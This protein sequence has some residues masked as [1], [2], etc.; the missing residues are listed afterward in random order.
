MRILIHRLG[1]LGDTIVALPVFKLIRETYP[2]AHITVLTNPPVSE[3]AAPLEAVIE[4]MGLV[5]EAL[6]YPMASR[7]YAKLAK[8]HSEIRRHRFDLYVSI[9]F[10][11]HITSSIRDYLYFKTCG[12]G[13]IIGLPFAHCDR[14][15]VPVGDGPLYEA[16]AT[17]LLRRA[18]AINPALADR[19]NPN[20]PQWTDLR[21]TPNELAQ[22]DDLLR[23][24]GITGNFLVASVG[25]KLRQKDWG[26]DRWNEL[27]SR[28]GPR[29][30]DF[31]MVMLGSADESSRSQALLDLW[32][33]P[34]ANL[35]GKCGPRV[36]AAVMRHA[37]LF[38]GHDSGP[39]H[40]AAAAG[41]RCV[42]I[43]CAHQPPGRWFPLGHGHAVFYP[44]KFYRSESWDDTEYQ[45]QAIA[46]ITADEVAEAVVKILG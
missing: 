6:Y 38:I 15:C 1:S 40:L 43:F 13:R 23:E 42:A 31:G 35:C 29:Y 24:A 37:R 36:S 9:T 7:D 30:P 45:I 25:S 19:I 8:L 39:M 5:D 4:N 32:S 44:Y 17:R 33:G 20:E 2:Q 3:K 16:E 46:S 41:I 14:V 18:R 11:R 26:T 21:L 12:I 10:G 22:G 27:F 34:K 28:L